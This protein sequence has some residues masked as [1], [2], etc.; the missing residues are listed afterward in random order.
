MRNR[1]VFAWVAAP[2]AILALPALAAIP[3][4]VVPPVLRAPADEEAAFMLTGRGAYVYQ[5]KPTALDPDAVAWGFVV[6]DAVLYDGARPAARITSVDLYE[7]I[8]DRS[9]VTGIVRA[10]A[11]GGPGNL[12]WALFRARAFGETGLFG[13]VTSFQRVNTNGGAAPRDG[14]DADHAGDE[15]RQNYTAD[16]YFYRKRNAPP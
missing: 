13:G 8:D 10:A 1:A 16:Y 11:P 12:P 4:P 14:C 2:L 9:S 5:C 7:A 15:A 6:P 3:A